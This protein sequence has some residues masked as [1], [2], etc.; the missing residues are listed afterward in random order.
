MRVGIIG[1]GL[2]GI[3]LAYQLQEYDNIEEILIFEKETRA[4]GLCRSF[5]S[6]G[7][8]FDVGPHILFSKDKNVLDFILDL[9]GE[10]KH[11]I[12]RSNRI[13]YKGRMVQYPFEND[14]SKLP[15]EDCDYCLNSFLNNPY[16]KY[17]ADNM[18]QFFLKT[19]GTGI[20][21]CY[22]RP[23]NEKIWKF[24]P[25]FMDT[26][27]VERIP[28]PPKQ[29][30][31]ASANGE[32]RDGYLHQL[33]FWY[34][35]KGGIESVI[36]GLMAKLNNKVKI[37][38]NAEINV[39]EKNKNGFIC[40]FNNK[41]TEY[42]NKLYSTM[43]LNELVDKL[44]PACPENV[45]SAAK[46]LKYNSIAIALVSI[47]EDLS[48]DNFAFMIPD[49]EIIFHRISKINFLGREYSSNNLFNYLIEITYRNDTILSSLSDNELLGRISEGLERIKF[50]NKESINSMSL[51]HK[52][53]YAYVIYDAEHK[54][55]T[56]LIKNFLRE[57]GVKISGRFGTWEYLNMDAVIK[58]AM[59][60][61]D[62]KC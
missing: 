8:V 19:F 61:E 54:K 53:K 58:Q 23:Y 52:F 3:T 40:E 18:L 27:M 21:N 25:A 44:K 33:Y 29:D 39:V 4:G 42:F 34:P 32:T 36:Q 46:N 30:I 6:N 60:L 59:S 55:N 16:E 5:E 31:I 1:A 35:K 62:N 38:Y 56:Q 2:S 7:V 45:Q 47:N 41:R 20:T 57:L 15:K 49:N 51:I 26:Q 11:Q 28:K 37:F 22:L 43:P 24:D 13:I 50:M 17:S 12:R 10:N 14:L 48:G 9:L